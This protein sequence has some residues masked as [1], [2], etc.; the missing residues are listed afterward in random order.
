MQNELRALR[1]AQQWR[2]IRNQLN[3][4][5]DP[6]DHPVADAISAQLTAR[7]DGESEQDAVIALSEPRD[8]LKRVT[9]AE[10]AL[11]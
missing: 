9:D 5:G 7:E 2:R 10:N 3:H 8:W 11:R 6:K 4:S 1:P